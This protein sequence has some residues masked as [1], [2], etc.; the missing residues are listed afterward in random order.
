VC[1]LYVCVCVCDVCVCAQSEQEG[2]EYHFVTRDE[3]QESISRGEFIESA[4]VHDQVCAC[5]LCTFVCACVVDVFSFM[6]MVCVRVHKCVCMC[7]MR[8]MCVAL[9]H[10]Q[11]DCAQHTEAGEEPSVG[12]RR[13]RGRAGVSVCGWTVFE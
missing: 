5:V 3:M 9:R 2:R 1:V 6:F 11:A 4:V 10:Q 8:R 13:T 12:A 7:I